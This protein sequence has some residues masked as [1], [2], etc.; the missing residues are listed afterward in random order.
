M[1]PKAT[2]FRIDPSVQAALE[3]LSKTLKR[4]MNQLVNEA[5]KAYVARRSAEVERDLEAT[6]ARL[7]AYR[8]RDP[9]FEEA[10]ER[11]AKAEAQFGKDDPTEGE[12]VFGTLIDGQLIEKEAPGPVQA[13]IDR[14]LHG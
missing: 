14:L 13:E 8:E 12:V 5:V 9:D 10:I 3:T 4:P 2:T 7:R 1:P 11:V 6:L